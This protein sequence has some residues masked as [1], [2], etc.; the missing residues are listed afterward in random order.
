MFIMKSL[1][2]IY[3]ILYIIIYNI[4][5][6]I[7]QEKAG[8]YVVDILCRKSRYIDGQCL[9]PPRVRKVFQHYEIQ[10]QIAN[11]KQEINIAFTRKSI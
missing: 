2:I 6:Y 1:N 11:H 4:L 5:L 9:G 3:Y 7:V 10:Q 8:H